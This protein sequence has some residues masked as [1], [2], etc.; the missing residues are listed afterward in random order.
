M[1]AFAG[2]EDNA[3]TEDISL[4]QAA[5]IAQAMWQ[6]AEVE[7][8]VHARELEMIT[9]FYA[10][11]A[12]AAGKAGQSFEHSPFDAATARTVLNTPVLREY[13]LRSCFLL[14]Y[15]DGHCSPAERSEIDA[16]AKSL[17]ISPERRDAV[18]REVKR[19]LLSQFEGLTVFKDVTYEIGRQL[20]LSAPEVDELLSHT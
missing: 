9:G 11:C 7:H 4:E 5:L 6:V 3:G 8:G 14:G 15:A 18:D 2:T 20:G 1:K 12:A 10:D 13:L 16:I 17:E 19:V